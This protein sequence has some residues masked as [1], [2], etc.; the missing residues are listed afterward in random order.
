MY[1][2]EGNI[3]NSSIMNPIVSAHIHRDAFGQYCH[4]TFFAVDKCNC[5][6]CTI[7]SFSLFAWIHLP[8]YAYDALQKHREAGDCFKR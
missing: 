6:V 3:F 4:V 1:H 5:P 7:L 8:N 2:V